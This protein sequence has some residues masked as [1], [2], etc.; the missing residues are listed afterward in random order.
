MDVASVA[1][2]RNWCYSPRISGLVLF[3]D[4]FFVYGSDKH[5]CVCIN[6]ILRGFSCCVAIKTTGF[7]ILISVCE[8]IAA[9]SNPKHPLGNMIRWSRYTLDGL[10]H[11]NFGNIAVEPIGSG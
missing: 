10:K 11:L 1:E 9:G 5:M 3:Q 6:V 2:Y 8:E 7:S 4:V